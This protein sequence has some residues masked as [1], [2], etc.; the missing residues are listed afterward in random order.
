MS[1]GHAPAMWHGVVSMDTFLGQIQ[2]GLH[3]RPFEMFEFLTSPRGK[4]V[5]EPAAGDV[6]EPSS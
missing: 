3:H 6:G 1:L 4:H 5:G 2:V